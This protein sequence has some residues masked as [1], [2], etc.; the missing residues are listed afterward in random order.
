MYLA[1]DLTMG[2]CDLDEDE[3]LDVVKIPLSDLVDDVLAGK[4]PD[5]K[6]QAAVMR[7]NEMLRR[8]EE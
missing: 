4:I 8:R 3:F 2:E 1:E 5:G 7:V 6:T